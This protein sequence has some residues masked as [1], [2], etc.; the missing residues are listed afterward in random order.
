MGPAAGELRDQPALD[1]AGGELP[2]LGPSAQ[3][4]VAEQPLELGGRE[5]GVG[6]E[7][8]SLAEERREPGLFELAAPVAGSAVLPDDGPCDG[9]KCAAVPQ[10]DRLALIGDA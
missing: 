3:V 6:D 2:L 10:H 1:R 7:S 5:V 8:R 9:G 4:G